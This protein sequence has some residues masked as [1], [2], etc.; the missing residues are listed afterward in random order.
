MKGLLEL[1]Q[2]LLPELMDL[3]QSRYRILQF[4]RLL[5]PI[6]RRTL[7][8]QLDITE[9]VVRSEVTLLKE[10]GLVN[11][12]QSGMH[13]TADGENLLEQLE[14]LMKEV[15]GLS[16]LETKLKD[17]L[18][19]DQVVV[20][21]GDSDKDELAKI[22]M[23]R[24]CVA[25][26][27]R[28]YQLS[29]II[30]VTGGTTLAAVA[31][32]MT[33]DLKGRKQLFVPARGGI[34]ENVTNQANT[35]CAKMADKVKGEYRLLHVP[36]QLSAAAYESLTAEPSIRDVLQLIK[37]SNLVIHGIGNALT[38]AQR[39]QT[40]DEDFAKIHQGQAVAESFGYYFDNEGNIVHRVTTAGLQ[41]EDLKNAQTVIAV[42][43]GASKASAIRAYMKQR[44]SSIL[45]T[46]EAAALTIV[47]K[48][49]L[50]K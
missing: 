24:A 16:V 17:I 15:L 10:Q 29:N 1:Q 49:S 21:S 39:R 18:Q 25:C 44:A 38:M 48:H 41:L 28:H 7:A 42:A 22:E 27:K 33:P 46:D 50:A 40:N 36:D 47:K 31:E 13:L 5:Q 30:A 34:G 45:V 26:M 43:G 32:M 12:S 35:I 3:M 8:Q 9:R 20:V 4:I 14:E 19:L 2:R 6:G 37:S 23:G 11:F